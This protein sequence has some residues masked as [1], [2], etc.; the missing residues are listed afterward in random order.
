MNLS[1]NKQQICFNNQLD[2]Q[3]ATLTFF[4]EE[5]RVEFYKQERKSKI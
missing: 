1:N 2:L 3:K 4:N 5:V